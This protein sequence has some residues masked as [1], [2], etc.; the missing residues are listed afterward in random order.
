MGPAQC[1]ECDLSTRSRGG[2]FRATDYSCFRVVG[3]GCY[4]FRTYHKALSDVTPADV[5]AGRRA[6]GQEGRRE[7][8]LRHR[9]EMKAK[10]I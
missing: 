6:G 9:K 7:E 5:L 1:P 3:W 10:T 8:I 2:P 4:N